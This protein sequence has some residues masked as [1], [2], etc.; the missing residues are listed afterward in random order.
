[1]TSKH[2][3]PTHPMQHS[4]A[5]GLVPLSYCGSSTQN[6]H[7]PLF[8]AEHNFSH[9]DAG[10][11]S[12]NVHW[13]N[14]AFIGKKNQSKRKGIMQT[15]V[16]P[17]CCKNIYL[18]EHKWNQELLG[19]TADEPGD[20]RGGDK[21]ETGGFLPVLYFKPT[22]AEKPGRMHSSAWHW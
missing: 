11:H 14:Q 13:Y 3:F 4:A 1:M 22:Q 16:Q 15:T 18:R 6:V 19:L 12:P 21:Q 2:M 7:P 10:R 17:L 20:D 8:Q 5:P 9:D